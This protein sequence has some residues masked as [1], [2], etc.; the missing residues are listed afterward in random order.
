MKLG[1]ISDT[2]DNMPKIA[3]AVELFNR[4]KVDLV[5][6]AGDFISPITANEFKRLKAKLIGVFGNNDG[7]KLYL[8]KR[9][10][11]IGEL[12]EDYHELELD[13]RRIVLMHQPKFL[14]ALIAS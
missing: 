3:R 8:L 9:Y 4:E 14:D 13:G 7:D 5:L 2:H 11:G 12:Y 1:I 6:H 10:K